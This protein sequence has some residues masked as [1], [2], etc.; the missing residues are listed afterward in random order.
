MVTL[1]WKA[2]WYKNNLYFWP[3]TPSHLNIVLKK[4]KSMG[5]DCR[6]YNVQPVSVNGV[7]SSPAPVISGVP[8][9]SIIGP[10]LFFILITDRDRWSYYQIICRWYAG[11]GY[12]FQ[13]RHFYLATWA[14]QD[15]QMVRCQQ[16]GAE[17]YK[18]WRCQLRAWWRSKKTS[19]KKHLQIKDLS[20]KQ[21]VKDLGVLL[22]GGQTSIFWGVHFLPKFGPIIMIF[23]IANVVLVILVE[24]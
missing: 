23:S 13:R 14:E 3:W 20:M 24:L 6:V 1:Y 22:S 12:P 5:I 21:T 9:G 17:R 19:S 2:L 8:Q 11:W 16:D 7:L 10:L 4:I 18:V 15:I